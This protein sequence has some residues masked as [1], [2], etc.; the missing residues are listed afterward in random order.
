MDLT[1]N[2]EPRAVR[3]GSTLHDLLHELRLDSR[4]VVVEHNREIVRDRAVLP[5]RT[6]AEGD[7]VELVQFVGGG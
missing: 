1:V 3:R 7:V 2:G 5:R 6:L 4:H